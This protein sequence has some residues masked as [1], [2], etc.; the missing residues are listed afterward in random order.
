MERAIN[1]ELTHKGI[2]RII[3]HRFES[4]AKSAGFNELEVC[5]SLDAEQFYAPLGFKKIQIILAAIAIYQFL[6][7]I[8]RMSI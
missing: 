8:M 6:S 2:G 7:V 4:N 5:S 3:F 1:P